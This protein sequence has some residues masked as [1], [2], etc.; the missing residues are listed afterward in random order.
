[1]KKHTIDE[2]FFYGIYERKW[3][4]ALKIAWNSEYQNAFWRIREKKT[5]RTRAHFIGSRI[6]QRNNNCLAYCLV[7][8]KFK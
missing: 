4:G 1:M 5:P 6:M 3:D 8:E 7:K 2:D